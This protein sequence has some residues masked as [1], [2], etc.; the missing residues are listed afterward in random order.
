MF[1]KENPDKKKEKKKKTIM[2]GVHKMVKHIKNHARFL[3]FHHFVDARH[4]SDQPYCKY[5]VRI[6]ICFTSLDQVKVKVL[7]IT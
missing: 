3:M 4:F 2:S 7:T 1:V 5:R 6:S